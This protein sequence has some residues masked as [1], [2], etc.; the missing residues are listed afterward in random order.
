MRGDSARRQGLYTRRMSLTQLRARWGHAPLIMVGVSL[1]LQDEQGRVLL[2]QRGDDG[3]WGTPGGGV[4]AGEDFLTAARRELHEET[5]LGCP[6]ELWPLHAGGLVSGPALYHR[7]PNGDEVYMVG[8][9]VA[10]HLPANALEHAAPDDS[11]E[12]LRLEWFGLDALPPLS[13]NINRENMNVLRGAAG[14][15][16]LALQAVPAPPSFELH[17]SERLRR[18]GTPFFVPAVQVGGR[19]VG[20]QYAEL[21]PSQRF[22]DV[23]AWLTGGEPCKA[24]GV[25]LHYGAQSWAMVATFNP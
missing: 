17:Y 21:E 13:G 19:Y 22:E 14:L 15:P 11:G 3:L 6:L 9:R 10:G 20:K 25:T 5:G 12:T 4:E 16:P 23:A 1:L 2:Q 7:Y 18:T 8:V 24:R